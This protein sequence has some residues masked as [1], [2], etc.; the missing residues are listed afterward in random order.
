M[1][2]YFK[3]ISLCIIYLHLFPFVFILQRQKSSYSYSNSWLT[4]CRKF[5]IFVTLANHDINIHKDIISWI[6]SWVLSIF[7][8]S[9]IVIY[10]HIF[11][12]LFGLKMFIKVKLFQIKPLSSLKSYNFFPFIQAKY[13]KLY[14]H[15]WYFICFISS[16][17]LH[18]T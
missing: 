14:C 9:K 4:H 2:A 1:T 17:E 10:E 12:N 18:N 15:T 16:M 11:G 3:I 6:L 5:E 7:Q 8:R 13:S